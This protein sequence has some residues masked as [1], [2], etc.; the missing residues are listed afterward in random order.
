MEVPEGQ[1]GGG[2]CGDPPVCPRRAPGPQASAPELPAP[3]G[4]HVLVTA[5]ASESRLAA[6]QPVGL[7]LP[8]GGC[9]RLLW[10]FN[11]CECLL[12]SGERG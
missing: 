7:F 5:G 3:E 2:G 4:R 6:L 11:K 1:G 9:G 8:V 12:L 10:P